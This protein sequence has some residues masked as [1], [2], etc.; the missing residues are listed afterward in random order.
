MNFSETLF[1]MAQ[2]RNVNNFI[3][4]T[5]YSLDILALIDADFISSSFLEVK[6]F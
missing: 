5:R 2:C 3:H 6:D 4:A 1:T